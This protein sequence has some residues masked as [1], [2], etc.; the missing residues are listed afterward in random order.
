MD[1][2]RE[3]ER[4]RRERKMGSYVFL[5]WIEMSRPGDGWIRL[6]RRL[7]VRD[8]VGGGGDVFRG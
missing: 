1:G 2:V 8:T 4:F 3:S 6:I 7:R 5:S